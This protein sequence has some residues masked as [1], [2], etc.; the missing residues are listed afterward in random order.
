MLASWGR[1]VY[2]FRWWVLIVAALTLVPAVWLLSKG[3][4]LNTVFV[5]TN[6]ES[7]QALDLVRRELPPTLPSFG[8]IFRNP[9]LQVTDSAFRAEVE[10]AVAPLRL[11]RHVAN[12]LTVYDSNVEDSRYV[13]RDGHST[14]VNVEI[15]DDSADNTALAM[16]I[17]P[18][19]RDKVR[20]DILEVVSFG[21]LPRN[22][23]FTVVAEKDIRHAELVV[24]PLV[25][26]LLVLVF[27]SVLAA[28]L[29]FAVGVLAVTGG[30]AATLALS[31]FTSILVFAT[32]IIIMVGLGVAIDYSLFIV[33]RFREEVHR[34]P[35]PEALANTMATTGRAILFSGGTV[36]IGLLG[37]LSLRLGPLSSLG[38]AGTIVVTLAVLFAMTFLPALLAV[39]GPRID[40][41]GLPFMNVRDT[42][43][44]GFW[45]RL[46][47]FVMA[48]PWRVLLPAAFFLLLLGLPFQHIQLSPT[49]VT[50]LPRTAESRLGDEILHREFRHV[51]TNPVMVVL[52]YP[53]DPV[54]NTGHVD[55]IYDLSRWLARLPGV[56]RVDSIVDLD[57]SISRSQYLQ[58]LTLPPAQTPTWTAAR[59]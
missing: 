14:I 3:G 18:K 19:L 7:G 12:V 29:P 49:D 53:H 6:A 46:A 51:D 11:D 17:Y 21:E 4:H 9:T 50:A 37:M 16:D 33:S 39:F 56:N 45:H 57:P 36:A 27:G 23:D 34:H 10:R 55:R 42:G 41:W 59:S 44:G 31:H 58:L 20:S 47:T 32:S 28:M 30:M 13:S 52:K 43:H 25:G 40:A 48:H 2:R 26:L 1:W 5:P 22:Y 54:L 38:L 8:L 24:L 15:R 35:V